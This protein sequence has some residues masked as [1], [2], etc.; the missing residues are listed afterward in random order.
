MGAGHEICWVRVGWLGHGSL[1]K[2]D[3]F[4]KDFI[5]LFMRDTQREAETQAEG[6][7]GSLRGARRGTRSQDPGVTSWA[8]GRCSTLEP[9]RCPPNPKLDFNKE[10]QVAL[11]LSALEILYLRGPQRTPRGF[12][13]RGEGGDWQALGPV[14]SL[15]RPRAPTPASGLGRSSPSPAP[16]PAPTFGPGPAHSPL[17]PCAPSLSFAGDQATPFLSQGCRADPRCWGAGQRLCRGAGFVWHLSPW[18]F[19]EDTKRAALAI[20]SP[21]SVPLPTFA[22]STATVIFPEATGGPATVLLQTAA[23]FLEPKPQHPSGP[24][25]RALG[26]KDRPRVVQDGGVCRA[27]AR[28][29]SRWP[30]RVTLALGCTQAPVIW[31]VGKGEVQRPRSLAGA[32]GARDGG[33]PG[34][35][36]TCTGQLP[37]PSV[38]SSRSKW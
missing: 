24:W 3:L 21:P 28:P 5:C 14:G 35:S 20:L 27:G 10:E 19:S 9:P 34:A 15:T 8:K 2:L 12:S 18:A 31:K 22:L 32:G 6:E 11:Y 37:P 26:W 13:P 29:P 30:G 23:A 25:Q 4:F 33:E 16:R 1:A 17:S 38:L 7:A 36:G